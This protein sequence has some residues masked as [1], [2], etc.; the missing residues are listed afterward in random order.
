MSMSITCA[1]CA[2]HVLKISHR[3]KLQ[4]IKTTEIN[5]KYNELK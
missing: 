5:W 4:F 1:E 2:L 3:K